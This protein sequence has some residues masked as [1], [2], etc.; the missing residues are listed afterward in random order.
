MKHNQKGSIHLMLVLALIILAVVGVGIWRILNGNSDNNTSSSTQISLEEN[1]VEEA[2]PKLKNIGLAS[3]SDIEINPFALSE[4][5]R[6]LKGFYVFGDP[7]EGGRLNPNFEFS[8]VKADAEVISAIDGIVVNVM[9]Q[10]ETKDYE[11]FI[12]P[13]EG[14]VWSLGYDH[15]INLKVEK[16]DS[17]VVGTVI[18]NPAIQNN[19]LHRFELQ[20]NSDFAGETIHHCPTTLLDESVR[21]DVETELQT[22]MDAWEGLGY[23]LYDIPSQSPIGCIKKELTPTE[24]EG[25]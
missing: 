16:G 13:K 9:E 17:V 12:L 3:L 21:A 1:V 8:S 25:R 19:G 5:S 22:M 23:E 14:S 11:V 18:G 7:L 24:A 2:A 6:G 20:I 4:F 15:L 10:P